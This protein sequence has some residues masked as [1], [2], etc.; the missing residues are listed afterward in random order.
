MLRGGKLSM[1]KNVWLLDFLKAIFIVCI[2]LIHTNTYFKLGLNNNLI[3]RYIVQ[4][5]VPYFM[6]ISGYTFSISTNKRSSLIENYQ[7]KIMVPKLIRFI[8]PMV[9]VDVIYLLMCM[10]T[11]NSSRIVHDI[12]TFSVGPG[13]YYFALMIELV[14]IFP[15]LFHL[16]SRG[17][18]SVIIMILINLGFEIIATFSDMNDIIYSRSV[19]RFIG[20]VAIGCWMFKKITGKETVK[21]YLLAIS[22]LLGGF[23]IYLTRYT[24]YT[25]V[26]FTKD[27]IYALPTLFWVWPVLYIAIKYWGKYVPANSFVEAVFSNVGK[28]SYHILTVQMLWFDF[29]FFLRKHVEL[30]S[31]IWSVLS[32]V[33]SILGGVV[34]FKIESRITGKLINKIVK[35]R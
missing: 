27:I 30:N 24:K 19:I 35:D 21:S 15:L 14:L 17:G 10:L 31:W 18:Y 12:I 32:F 9:I 22:G 25:S 20:F 4:L 23:W 34:F 33:V 6:V 28:A 11:D 13:S 7:Y 16:I 8:F 3:F 2:I 1:R 5:A 26:I 29:I